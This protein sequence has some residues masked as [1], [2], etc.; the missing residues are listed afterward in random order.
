MTAS[1]NPKDRI[2]SVIKYLFNYGYI[3]TIKITNTFFFLSKV[4]Y[5]KISRIEI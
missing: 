2:Y 3:L 5:Q 1:I 4:C